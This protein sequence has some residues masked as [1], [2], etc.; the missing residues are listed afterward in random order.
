MLNTGLTLLIN[1]SLSVI[2]LIVTSYEIET[3]NVSLN[4]EKTGWMKIYVDQLY[5]NQSTA[6]VAQVCALIICITS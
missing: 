3:A 6:A 5:K 4:N 2:F 1:K